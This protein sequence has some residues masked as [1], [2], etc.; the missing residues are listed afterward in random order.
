MAAFDM[1]N[2]TVSGC[3]MGANKARATVPTTS[4]QQNA[5]RN[6]I[7]GGGCV[8]VLFYGNASGSV[9]LVR[10]NTFYQ[11]LVD[12]SLTDNVRVGNGYGGAVSV[13]YGLSAGLRRLDVSFFN[14]VFQENAFT[15]CEVNVS[16]SFG[17]NAY[18][19]GVSVYVGS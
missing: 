14:M 17:G 16:P 7:S 5:S 3:R 1:L 15:G 10:G 6:A 12:V 8:S 18:G 11:C 9:V 4:L 19:G 13:Y 2:V